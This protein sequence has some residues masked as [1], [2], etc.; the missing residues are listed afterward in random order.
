[1]HTLL[2][3]H[4]SKEGQ[5]SLPK[6]CCILLHM[7]MEEK[8]FVPSIPSSQQ[9]LW[10]L[11]A[12]KELFLRP[13]HPPFQADFLFFI[14]SVCTLSLIHTQNILFLLWS[15]HDATRSVSI[16]KDLLTLREDRRIFHYGKY[17]EDAV[18]YLQMIFSAIR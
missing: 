1:M 8:L 4:I 18:Q 16:L 9:L 17:V 3:A 14:L 10:S 2:L 15:C 13:A 5:T 7:L 12:C 11:L 6:H